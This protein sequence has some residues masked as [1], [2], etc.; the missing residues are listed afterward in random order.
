MP[1]GKCLSAPKATQIMI[2]SDA[3]LFNAL[4]FNQENITKILPVDVVQVYCSN[5]NCISLKFKVFKEGEYCLSRGHL[6]RCES[7]NC[8]IPKPRKN[9]NPLLEKYLRKGSKELRSNA[10]VC[11][12]K[13]FVLIPSGLI[14]F[15]KKFL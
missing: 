5:N 13:I 1:D 11:Y 9:I 3:F 2:V 14:Y 15:S 10:S 8:V 6:G 4:K 12:F 7:S